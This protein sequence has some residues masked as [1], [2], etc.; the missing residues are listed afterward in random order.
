MGPAAAK[1]WSWTQQALVAVAF[2]VLWEA[3]VVIGDVPHYLVPS[4]F[5]VASAIWLGL[6][7]GLFIYHGFI[8]LAATL[9]GFIGGAIIGFV[10]GVLISQVAILDRLIYPYVVAFQTVP[11]V[12]IAPLVVIWFGFGIGSKIAMA[13]MICFFP[14]VVNTIEGLHSVKPERIMLL[15]SYSASR[16]DIFRFVQLPA[17]LPFIFA[18]LDVGIVLAVIGTVVGEFV[19]SVEGLGYILLKF[20]HEIR[21]DGVFASIVVLSLMGV[22]LHAI[23]RLIQRHVVFWSKPATIIGA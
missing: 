21:I 15:R 20:N 14:V 2:I 1:A 5:A 6:E 16:V 7:S 4:P 18:G 9:I 8:T 10:L 3:A 11:K 19:G 23:L 12:A 22:G 17:A 13:L